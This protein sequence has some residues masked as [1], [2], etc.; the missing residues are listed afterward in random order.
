MRGQLVLLR[1]APGIMDVGIQKPNKIGHDNLRLFIVNCFSRERYRNRLID[2][3]LRLSS[4]HCGCYCPVGQVGDRGVPSPMN[5]SSTLPRMLEG[6]AL[7]IQIGGGR[8]VKIYLACRARDAQA[9]ALG[10]SPR[11]TAWK[12]FM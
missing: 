8:Y 6:E 9:A 1:G 12:I 11:P 7:T 5:Y 10:N 4:A 3:E 2:A